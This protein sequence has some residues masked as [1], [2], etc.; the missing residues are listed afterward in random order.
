VV[1]ADVV[2]VF[3][4]LWCPWVLFVVDISGA[5]VMLP[6][7]LVAALVIQVS[8]G[9]YSYTR[10]YTDVD[11]A[12]LAT[13]RSPRGVANIPSNEINRHLGGG[14]HEGVLRTPVV[15][16]ASLQH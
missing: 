4:I 3:I 5:V 7:V 14:M 6:V 8:C 2:A 9:R 13:H 11:Q 10:S 16:S 12:R 1:V 15:G